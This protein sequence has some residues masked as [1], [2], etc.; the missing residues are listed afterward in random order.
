ME[1]Q[2][3]KVWSNGSWVDIEIGQ[4]V[5]IGKCGSGWTVI[6]ELGTFVRATKQ[7]CVFRSDSGSEVKTPLEDIMKTSGVWRKEGWWVSLRTEREYVHSQP[8]YWN[9]RKCE[10]CYK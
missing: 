1:G 9:E 10:L 6:G 2:D 3:M 5:F 4:R 7:H 8:S